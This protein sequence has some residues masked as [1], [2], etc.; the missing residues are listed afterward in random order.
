MKLKINADKLRILAEFYETGLQRLSRGAEIAWTRTGKEFSGTFPIV[1]TDVTVI[2]VTDDYTP[3]Q[4][5]EMIN[6]YCNR[7][8]ELLPTVLDNELIKARRE[9]NDLT[10]ALPKYIEV[11]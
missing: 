10:D 6:F 5:R 8:I 3:D 2:D 7:E 4:W 9:V 11:M 1:G